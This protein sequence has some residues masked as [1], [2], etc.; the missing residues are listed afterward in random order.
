MSLTS[1]LTDY[2][3]TPLSIAFRDYGKAGLIF[4]IVINFTIC[5]IWHG[6]NWTYVLFGFLHGC[7][8]IPLIVKGT[9]NKRK[10]IATDK[11]LPSFGELIN[12]LATFTLVMF[13]FIIFRS[14]SLQQGYHFIHN[15]F[16]RSLFTTPD[17]MPWYILLFIV[18]FLTVEWSGR[19][20]EFAIAYM[21]L[22]LNTQ[23][24]WGIYLIFSVLILYFNFYNTKTDFIY[25]QF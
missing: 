1:W 24:R 13:T 14:E 5:G 15:I 25:F 21:G 17:I 22:K 10:K 2:V 3:F 12:V 23:I 11:L 8:F 7:Y 4:A 19:E 16:T 6:A 20:Y 9:M 18:F